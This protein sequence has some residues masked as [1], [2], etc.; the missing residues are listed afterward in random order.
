M[1]PDLSDKGKMTPK[2]R[3]NAMIG[4]TFLFGVL[5]S[6]SSAQPLG[7]SSCATPGSRLPCAPSPEPVAAFQ[8]AYTFLMATSAIGPGFLTQT[9]VFTEQ[10]MASF[11]FVIIISIILDVGAQMNI[12]RIIA[13]A[14]KR[15]QDIAND[16]LPGV[17]YVV[18]FFI[19]LG[20]LA[21]NIGNVGGGGLGANALIGVDPVVGSILTG[22]ICIV[23]RSKR[24][25]GSDCTLF[26]NCN[27][28]VYK[29]CHDYW[30]FVHYLQTLHSF[31][32]GGRKGWLLSI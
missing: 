12:W 13:V 10:L 19:V 23:I 1:K 30:E 18:A 27:D 29:L 16:V 32:K 6:S 5:R 3:L 15:G 7:V 21:F 31:F 11:A 24:C 14:K 28:C 22:I 26:R 9:A 2:Q 20:G 25:N 17:G 4:A 8:G